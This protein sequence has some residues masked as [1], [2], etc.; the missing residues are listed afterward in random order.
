MLETLREFASEQLKASGESTEFQGRAAAWFLSLTERAAPDFDE[1]VRIRA[2][3]ARLDDE[4]PNVR[5]ALAWYEQQ[6]DG[7]S[8]LTLTGNLDEY[9]TVRSYVGEARRW[10]ETGLALM[11][12]APLSVRAR[13]LHVASFMASDQ[14]DF[15]AALDFAEAG[16][17]AATQ[18][19][20]PFALGRAHFNRALAYEAMGEHRQSF[21]DYARAV[22]PLKQTGMF[23]FAGMSL[24]NQADQ[25]LLGGLMTDTTPLL[26]EALALLGVTGYP[27]GVAVVLAQQGYAARARGDLDTARKRFIDSFEIA[28][29]N[30]LVRLKLGAV[31]GL[32]AI[33]LDTGQKEIAAMALGAIES[34]AKRTGTGRLAHRAHFN[35]IKEAARAALGVAEFERLWGE[36]T[37]MPYAA[38]VESLIERPESGPSG[39]RTPP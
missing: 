10:I 2:W 25:A 3:C 1:G 18:M 24:G 39:D 5:D 30:G 7:A 23:A 14:G 33:A 20:D 31:S 26:D 16:L 11:P 28:H 8:I 29:T 37:A 38:V 4:F 9:W 13:A 34:E 27:P 22:Q 19:N 21:E 12:D 6:G 36:G 17:A 15:P 35:R 32:A